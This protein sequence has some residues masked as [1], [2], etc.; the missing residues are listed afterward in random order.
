MFC[1]ELLSRKESYCCS[2]CIPKITYL[3]EPFCLK[4]G[5]EI[6]SEEDEFCQ[7]CSNHTRS[8]VKGFPAL[9]YVEPVSEAV[10]ALK[11]KN[12]RSYAE[13]FAREIVKI[14]GK[15]IANLG[16]EALIPV[17]IHPKKL[18][19]RG[20]NQAKI[21]ADRLGEL[22]RIPVDDEI[23]FRDRNT[24]PQKE[25][26]SIER[27]KNLK[28]AFYSAKEIVQYKRVLLVDDIYTT[29]ATIEACTKILQ[30]IGVSGVYYTSICI[31]KGN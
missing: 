31:G 14:H 15:S 8:F 3:S 29:G 25:L 21:I 20:Y 4:C 28:N 2:E 30:Q 12:K 5:K 18:K 24:L 10:G 17:P 16:V 22:M 26:D 13:Y 6:D 9:A 19:K 27:E 11:Y 7:D 23:L 1:G